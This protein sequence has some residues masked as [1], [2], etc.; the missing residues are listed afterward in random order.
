[1]AS[2]R[3]FGVS[4]NLCTLCD[5]DIPSA[6]YDL[7]S[8]QCKG[9][10]ER[11]GISLD[12]GLDTG[13]DCLG[14]DDDDGWIKDLEAEVLSNEKEPASPVSFPDDPAPKVPSGGLKRK[15]VDQSNEVEQPKTLRG[16]DT[17]NFGKIPPELFYSIL[18]FLS[19]EDLSMCAG[20]CQF[21]RVATSDENLWRR[22]YCLRW[23]P[24]E[25]NERNSKLRGC[26]WKQ[27]YFERDQADMVEFVRNTPVEFREYYIQMQVAKRSQAP[28]PS[29]I[30]DDLVVIDTSVTDHVTAWRRGHKLPDVYVGDHSCSG[31]TC[32]YYQIGDI[33]LCERTGRAHVCDDTCRETVLDPSNDLLV[34]TV[35]GRCFDR[36][37]DGDDDEEAQPALK[38]AEINQAAEEGEPFLNAGRLGRAYLLGYNCADERELDAALREVVYPG[39]Q[40]QQLLS[41]CYDGDCEV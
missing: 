37:L 12:S 32:S 27:L 33:F 22:L 29:Q 28:A 4:T 6:S 17:G 36:W 3:G 39:A 30:R 20:V 40:K 9:N 16:I 21:L 8:A 26:A 14:L 18:K 34:C 24:P 1:M 10:L 15:R 7:H 25:R 13:P 41:L 19:S 35:S 31:R 23:G 11:S 38:Q 2:L 5:R